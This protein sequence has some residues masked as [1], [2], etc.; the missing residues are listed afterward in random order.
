MHMMIV[1]AI[2]DG[3]GPDITGRI[4]PMPAG[5]YHL[6]REDDRKHKPHGWGAQHHQRSI[7]D[8]RLQTVFCQPM[9]R[10]G[11]LC[12]SRS[13]RLSGTGFPPR[14]AVHRGV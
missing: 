2:A 12:A 6:C 10:R 13:Y 1:K 5:S 11:G 8:S 4:V 7:A 3:S 9:R 14:Y